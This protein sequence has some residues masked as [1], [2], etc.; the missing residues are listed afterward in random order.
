MSQVPEAGGTASEHHP[1][2]GYHVTNG[3]TSGLLAHQLSPLAPF[4]GETTP[5]AETIEEWLERFSTR[6]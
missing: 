4:K 5:D 1:Q 3:L 2:T 6:M